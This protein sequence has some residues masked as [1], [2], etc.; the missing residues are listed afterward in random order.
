MNSIFINP[1]DGLVSLIF[2]II[3]LVFII[4]LFLK[5]EKNRVNK[6]SILL[7]I[8]LFGYQFM[9]Y[10]IC[11]VGLN[12]SFMVYLAFVDISFLPPL[13]LYIILQYW[14]HKS[15]RYLLL[16]VPAIFFSVYYPLVIDQFVVTKCTV[17]YAA[18]N[19]PLGF[20]Y[21]IFYYTPIL[22]LILFIL[23]KL[24]TDKSDRRI[25]LSKVLLWGYLIAFI[26]GVFITRFIPGM[27]AAVESILCKFAFLL[28]IFIIYFVLK[29]KIK[30]DA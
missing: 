1:P 27:L 16:F 9:E 17:M 23:F 26:P 18:Y 29:N 4:I 8:L 10:L 30:T 6:L 25:Y 24:K 5:S 2:S 22:I 11:G 12:S 20:L 28:A 13:A 14:D 15:K 7:L 19:Y 3:E 21:G